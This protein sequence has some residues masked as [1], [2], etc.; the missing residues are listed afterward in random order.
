MYIYIICIYIYIYITISAIIPRTLVRSLEKF[1]YYPILLIH[2][3]IKCSNTN[4]LLA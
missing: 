4:V 2:T 3:Y 1:A